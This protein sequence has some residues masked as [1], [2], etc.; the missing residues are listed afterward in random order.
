MKNILSPDSQTA[1]EAIARDRTL[2]AFDFDGTLAPLV[3]DHRRARMRDSTRTLLRLTSLLHPCAVISGRA[4]ADIVGRLDGVPLVAIVGNHGADPGRGPVDAAAREIVSGW[5]EDATLLLDSV[6]GVEIEDKGLS[7]AIHYRRAGA[8]A[9]RTVAAVA[10]SLPH[11]RILQGHW[12]IHVVV[13]DLADKGLALRELLSRTR[14]R[15]AV[16]MGDDATDEAAF[17]AEGVRVSVRVGEGSGSFARYYLPSQADVDEFL[18]A[19]IRARRR[20]EGLGEA[21]GGLERMLAW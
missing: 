1:L 16:Y 8:A 10:A 18:R 12:V 6:P 5:R 13:P 11:A 20:L 4:R 7:L 15:E 19:L 21:I 9:G 17:R 2:L 14:R 3:E